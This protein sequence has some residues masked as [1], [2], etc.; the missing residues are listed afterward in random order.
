MN[1]VFKANTNKTDKRLDK[2]NGCLNNAII[3]FTALESQLLTFFKES[4]EDSA[5][6]FKHSSRC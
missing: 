4:L 5:F 6:L 2:G 1:N 3:V